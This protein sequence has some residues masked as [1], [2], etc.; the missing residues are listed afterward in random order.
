MRQPCLADNAADVMVELCERNDFAWI[1]HWAGAETLSRW[2]IG[3]KSCGWIDPN[4][5]QNLTSC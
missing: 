1:R 4:G 2:E 3:Q 5:P